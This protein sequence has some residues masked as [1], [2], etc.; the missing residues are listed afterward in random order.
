MQV[1]HGDRLSSG[2]VDAS[3]C[4]GSLADEK[5]NSD[6]HL[7]KDLDRA[8]NKETSKTVIMAPKKPLS[9]F[10]FFSQQARRTFKKE[11]PGLH[12]K[13]IMAMVQK[14]WKR[15]SETDKQFYMEQSKSDRSEYD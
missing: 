12:A 9:P 14:Q 13:E 15:M 11:N 7:Q 3:R 1:A 10:I 5:G 2:D 4:E 8:I 6:C